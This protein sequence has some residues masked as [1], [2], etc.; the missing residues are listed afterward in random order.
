MKIVHSY[1][2]K[3]NIIKEDELHNRNIGG[4]IHPAFHYMSWDLSCLKLK[5]FYPN[6]ELVT[7]S[8]EKNY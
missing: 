8:Q 2:S 4:W 6:I 7:D 3:P 1:C 5:E